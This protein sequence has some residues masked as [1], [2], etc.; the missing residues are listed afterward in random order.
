MYTVC[1]PSKDR[2]VAVVDVLSQ[3]NSQNRELFKLEYVKAHRGD[4]LHVQYLVLCSSSF[5]PAVHSLQDS[6]V[7]LGNN[8][9][10]SPQILGTS[11][12]KL[13]HH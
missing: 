8:T 9:V 7:V 2:N 13:L 10:P 4:I 1:W 11:S 5:P 3:L 12:I 6:S